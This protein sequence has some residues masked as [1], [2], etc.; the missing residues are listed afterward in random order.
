MVYYEDGHMT[1]AIQLA[2]ENVSSDNGGPFGAVV[3]R[4]GKVIAESGN[5]V[6][7]WGDPTAHAEIVAIRR[8]CELLR[9]H[10][11]SDCILYASCEPCPMCLGAIYWAHLDRVYFATTREDA[12]VAG[13][14]DAKIYAEISQAPEYREIPMLHCIEP[15]A[16]A[17]FE[18]WLKKADR[19]MY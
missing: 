5:M 1:R 9:T 10:D 12:A 16:T 13:F 2:R 4:D 7:A 19:T 17:P 11:L 8:A 15:N 3:V 6:L 14:D 18:D